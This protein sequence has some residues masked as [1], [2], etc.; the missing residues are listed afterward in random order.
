MNKFP[1]W[2]VIILAVLCAVPLFAEFIASSQPIAISYDGKYY[3]P[4]FW[5]YRD[6]AFGGDFNVAADYR[7]PYLQQMIGKKGGTIIWPP[8]RYSY[9]TINLN[10]PTPAPSMPTWMLTESE[11]QQAVKLLHL[12][13]CS[14]LEYNWLGTDDQGRDVAA[15]LIYGYRF[16]L[17]VGLGAALIWLMV[18]AV[19]RT[20]QGRRLRDAL[21]SSA[22]AL[23]K[24]FTISISLLI[25]LDFFGSGV[26]P[27]WPSIGELLRQGVVN[28]QASWLLIGS[29]LAIGMLEIFSYVAGR[30]LFAFLRRGQPPRQS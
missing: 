10:L 25:V 7:D 15:R 8:I 28:P 9:D 29:V 27:G 21:S 14:D 19:V 13:S 22:A 26:P 20:A 24:V 30:A 6:V 23:P 18:G 11:C 17:L 1:R 2:P 16:S 5:T 3:F 12:K 4:I